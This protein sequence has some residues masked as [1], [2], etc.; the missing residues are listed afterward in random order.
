MKQ[1]EYDNRALQM[2]Y[3]D[4]RPVELIAKSPLKFGKLLGLGL[5]F[6]IQEEHPQECELDASIERFTR[7]VRLKYTFAGCPSHDKTSQKDIC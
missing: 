6:C 7:D 2:A 3:H 5:K 4:L 1:N